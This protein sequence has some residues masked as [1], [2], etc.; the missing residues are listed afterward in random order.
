MT[1]APVGGNEPAGADGDRSRTACPPLWNVYLEP[2]ARCNLDCEHCYVE[3]TDASARDE[4]T[5]DELLSLVSQFAELGVRQVILTGGEALLRADLMNVVRAL[6]A[7]RIKVVLSTN[8]LLLTREVAR[9]LAGGAPGV[10]I[11]VSLDGLT[12]ESHGALRGSPGREPSFTFDRAVGAVRSSVDSGLAASVST[13]I[14]R[15]NLLELA[16]MRRWL[17]DLGVTSWWLALPKRLG[18]FAENAGRHEVHAAE[19]LPVLHGLLDDDLRS[20]GAGRARLR[21]EVEGLYGSQA[22]SGAAVFPSGASVCSRCNAN[23]CAIKPN[24]DV[25]RCVYLGGMPVG[26]LRERSLASLWES[27]PMQAL[28]R[29]PVSDVAACAG[30]RVPPPV[31]RGMPGE[32]LGRRRQLL[33]REGRVALRPRALRARH[34]ARPARPARPRHRVRIAA[35]RGP[36]DDGDPLLRQPPRVAERRDARRRPRS[37]PPTGDRL[38]ARLR[39]QA[40]RHRQLPVRAGAP[41]LRGERLPPDGELRGRGRPRGRRLRRHRAR[42]LSGERLVLDLVGRYPAKRIV[43][44]GCL[45]GY[46]PEL[47]RHANVVLVPPGGTDRLSDLFAGGVAM[48]EVPMEAPPVRMESVQDP[49]GQ[50][51]SDAHLLISQGCVHHCTY[52]NVKLVK[53]AVRSRPLAELRREAVRLVE[54][55]EREIMLLADDCGSWGRDLGS[56]FAA[57]VAEL[58]AIDERVKWKVYYLFPGLFLEYSERLWQPLADGRLSYLCVPM[59]SGSRR[60]LNLMNRN[61]DPD[62]VAERLHALRAANPA[63]YLFSHFIFDF[64]SESVEEFE[65]SL[66]LMP[67]FDACLLVEYSDNPH[68]R[69]ARLPDRCDERDRAAKL[70]LLS[71]SSRPRGRRWSPWPGATRS[72]GGCSSPVR[73]LVEVPAIHRPSLHCAPRR[74]AGSRG[75]KAS[76][77]GDRPLPPPSTLRDGARFPVAPRPSRLRL[78]SDGAAPRRPGGCR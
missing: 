44:F 58:V 61:Y 21:L 53:G 51:P 40:L 50:R 78:G 57:L 29:Y 1:S 63:V 19:L 13:M 60:I 20:R 59:Q 14:H 7:R 48:G 56:D 15:G 11:F 35:P 24:G 23:G 26:N 77:A 43:V 70:E 45:A 64:P 4:L 55:G 39:R 38:P 10:E 9:T 69:A 68:T 16:A 5:S 32:R 3:R 2:T 34:A 71:A 46:C 76:V 47:A 30:C 33:R 37:E 31:R 36:A 67:L 22:P 12:P 75:I 17:S 52:C 27:A 62:R 25:A 42:T 18:R 49:Q 66:R 65:L 6:L 54:Q 73:A 74:V 41:V 72:T 8:G 28:V